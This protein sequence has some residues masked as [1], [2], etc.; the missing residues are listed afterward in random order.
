MVAVTAL[1][2]TYE[3]N[4]FLE[5]KYTELNV[6]ARKQVD[7]LA[8]NIYYEAGY[9]ETRGQLAVAL[10]TMNRTQ[11]PR[12]PK[13]ICSVVKQKTRGTCQFSW[14]CEPIKVKNLY[15]YRKNLEVALHAYANY[16]YIDDLTKGA[17]YYHADYI[18]PR[19]KLHKTT[20]IG[21]HI[22]YKDKDNDAKAELTTERRAF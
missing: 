8:E 1:S 3:P 20:Q 18:N 14:F 6:D 5:I 13:D 11:D 9:E 7:C 17:I 15:V 4:K 12:F 2:V 21:R 19:W 16:E 10:V 22:F